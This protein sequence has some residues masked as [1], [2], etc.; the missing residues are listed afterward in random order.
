MWDQ[1]YNTEEYM[2]GKE[3]NQFLASVSSELPKGR[4][5]CLAEGEGRNAV[6][7]AKQGCQ[8]LAV[9]SSAVGLEKAKKLAEANNVTIGT[10]AADLAHLVIEPGKWDAI[11]SIFAHVPSVIRKE[12]HRKV[13]KGLRSGGVFI[14]E[15]YTPAQLAL[16]TGGPP[17]EDMMMTL[18]A[19]RLEL[20]GLEFTHARE[21]E[22]VIV[23]GKLHTGKGAVVQV[24]A[25]KP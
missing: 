2:Y 3:P 25:R 14:L 24:V 12:L 15:A 4:V 21:L 19:L 17:N 16:K 5:L 6:F 20:E 22:R 10:Q 8:V 1:R 13:V 7:L 9:D 18:E 23:E 11:V